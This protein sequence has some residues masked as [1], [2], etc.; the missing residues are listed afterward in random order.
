M[1]MLADDRSPP[2]R[3]H[4]G[5]RPAAADAF[6]AVS[7]PE[8]FTVTMSITGGRRRHRPGGRRGAGRDRRNGRALGDGLHREQG[9]AEEQEGR[10]ASSTAQDR[11]EST[12]PACIGPRTGYG[13]GG[14]NSLPC[15]HRWQTTTRPTRRPA[16][17]LGRRE[18]LPAA[19][20][21]PNAPAGWAWSPGCAAHG[22]R[23]VP[24][25]VRPHARPRRV[26]V[27]V[28]RP[29]RRVPRPTTG[30]RV[31]GRIMLLRD[32]GKL[33]FATHPRPFRRRP[34]VRVE[35]R[36]GRRRVRRGQANSTSATGSASPAP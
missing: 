5:P 34:A 29:A 19:A 11:R 18:P 8:L 10:Q 4:R 17:R 1:P 20:W 33:I 36:D 6:A 26:A 25:P 35:G 28:G 24:V 3:R 21:Q 32:S 27:H 31:A 13:R 2:R 14:E 23:S 30:S 15:C 9:R 12:A 7:S 22:H 16:R